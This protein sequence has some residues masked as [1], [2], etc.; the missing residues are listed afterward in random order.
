MNSISA[1]EPLLLSS[2]DMKYAIGILEEMARRGLSR[3]R[4]AALTIIVIPKLLRAFQL[5][6]VPLQVCLCGA[7][8]RLL[9]ES[10]PSTKSSLMSI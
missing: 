10:N 6:T 7:L 3:L 4:V 5:R 9:S 2:V 8:K 1:E